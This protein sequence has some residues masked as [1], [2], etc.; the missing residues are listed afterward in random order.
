MHLT[1]GGEEYTVVEG[2]DWFW[3]TFADGS[4]E[5]TTFKIF[6]KFIDPERPMLDIGAWIGPTALYAAKRAKKVFAFEP[7]PAAFVSLVQNLSLNPT[8]NVV[9]YPV[10]VS[11]GWGGIP[12]GVKGQLGD[13]M[14]SVLWAKDDSEVPAV[15]LVGLLVDINPAF[16]KIDIEGGEGDIFKGSKLILEQMK[17]TIHLSLHTPWIKNVELFKKRIT[18]ELS[19]YPYFYDE[20]LQPIKLEDA[21]KK[22]EFNSLVASFQKI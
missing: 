11:N 5:P 4:W 6:D 10:A 8:L 22:D 17:P 9:P 13:S 1:R 2:H 12:F 19:I 7:D 18:S 16:V 14:S 21:F 20:N 3:K 15:P